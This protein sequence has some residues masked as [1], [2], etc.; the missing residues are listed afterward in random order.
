LPATPPA[1]ATRRAR[2][3]HESRGPR[4][5]L[6]LHIDATMK[7]SDLATL[8]DVSLDQITGGFNAARGLKRGFEWGVNG[9]VSGL[10][11]GGAIGT[12]VPGVGTAAGMA[13]GTAVGGIGGFAAG[14][15][16]GGSCSNGTCG[17]RH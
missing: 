7:T 8:T 5:A 14:F 13:I 4:A 2:N 16:A 17:H 1:L 3:S 11:T 10:I 9:A 15:V 12:A 6:A